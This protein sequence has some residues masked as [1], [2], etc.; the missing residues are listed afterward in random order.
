MYRYMIGYFRYYNWRHHSYTNDLI[1]ANDLCTELNYE[2]GDGDEGIAFIYDTE[3][4]EIWQ[5]YVNKPSMIKDNYF[6]VNRPLEYYSME[7][8]L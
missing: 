4:Q 6:G 2:L 1:E 5:P 3:T 7:N 8:P